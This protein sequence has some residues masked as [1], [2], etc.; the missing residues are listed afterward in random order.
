MKAKVIGI[1][2][3]GSKAA[4]NL[5]EKGVMKRENII[6]INSTIGDVPVNYRDITVQYS[7]STGGAGKERKGST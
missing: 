1:G 7:N 6:L 5:I 2:A 3:A 4:I